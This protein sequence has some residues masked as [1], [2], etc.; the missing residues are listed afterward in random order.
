MTKVLFKEARK[1]FISK[2]IRIKL[3]TRI[4][5]ANPG[6]SN[7]FVNY[8]IQPFYMFIFCLFC[9]FFLRCFLFIFYCSI[10]F[11]GIQ[12]QKLKLSLVSPKINKYIL[13][14]YKIRELLRI[15]RTL[16]A[17]LLQCSC[18]KF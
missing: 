10:H 6:V 3:I 15:K 18:L 11:I 9:C 5:L 12:E 13:S 8:T 14:S 17:M 7:I 1:V 2:S 4:Q 16:I